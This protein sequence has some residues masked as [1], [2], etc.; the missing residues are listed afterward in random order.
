M[1]QRDT[2]QHLISLQD[3]DD[4]TLSSILELSMDLKRVSVAPGLAGKSSGLLFFRRSLR[5]PTPYSSKI[6]RAV[7]AAVRRS[8]RS[9]GASPASSSSSPACS[10]G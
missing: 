10:W 6:L 3:L 1:P 4:A 9:S 2:I 8:R 7:P 5:I